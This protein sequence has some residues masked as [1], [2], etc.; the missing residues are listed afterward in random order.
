MCCD[1][2]IRCSEWLRKK[3]N[4]ITSNQDFSKTIGTHIFYIYSESRLINTD[5]WATDYPSYISQFVPRHKFSRFLAMYQTWCDNLLVSPSIVFPAG[6]HV[7]KKDVRKR[8]LHRIASFVFCR[9]QE[10]D[11]SSVWVL[12]HL[13][14]SSCVTLASWGRWSLC[15][16]TAI[17]SSMSTF[18]KVKDTFSFVRYLSEYVLLDSHAFVDVHIHFVRLTAPMT[19]GEWSLVR[20]SRGK[21]IVPF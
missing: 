19:W 5:K 12:V 20:R 10:S 3:I 1:H 2:W 14:V 21:S 17:T 4:C 16:A 11:D 9:H 15:T 18:T 13:W 6:M 7:W 8:Y